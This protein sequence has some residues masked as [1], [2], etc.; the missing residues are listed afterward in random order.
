MSVLVAICLHGS[1]GI[2]FAVAW[3]EEFV[4]ST[5]GLANWNGLDM[6]L[7]LKRNDVCILTT[8]HTRG[9]VVKAIT[10]IHIIDI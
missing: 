5:S 9:L 6:G 2:G 8:I 7:G 4:V 10:R 1:Y 3:R